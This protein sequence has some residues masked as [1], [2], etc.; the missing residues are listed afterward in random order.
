MENRL[1]ILPFARVSVVVL[2]RTP[3]DLLITTLENRIGAYL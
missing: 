3:H 2:A 1:E